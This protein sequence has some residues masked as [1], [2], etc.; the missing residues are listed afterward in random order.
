MLTIDNVMLSYNCIAHHY[1]IYL[2]FYYIFCHLLRYLHRF[3][4]ELEQIEL[5]NGIKGRQGRLHGARETVIKQTM[6]RERALYE[7]NG[8][9]ESGLQGQTIFQRKR[10]AYEL[11]RPRLANHR[12]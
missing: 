7:G 10:A 5:V 9:G 3:D 1:S 6:E 4:S 8:F 12:C 2:Y 11:V